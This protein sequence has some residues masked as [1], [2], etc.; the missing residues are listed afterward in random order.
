MKKRSIIMPLIGICILIGVLAIGVTAYVRMNQP[1]PHLEC[2]AMRPMLSFNGISYVN[3]SQIELA[4]APAT[5][6]LDHL[7]G[8]GGFG[9]HDVQYDCS[10]LSTGEQ[11]YSL[12]GYR[13][14]F[15]LAVRSSN[16]V[17]IFDIGYNPKA[18]TGADLFDLVN[19]VQSMAVAPIDNPD[20]PATI[21]SDPTTVQK[22][23]NEVLAAPVISNCS[24][25]GNEQALLF[26]MKDG[27][28]FE[29]EYWPTGLGLETGWPQCVQLPSNF[30]ASLLPN[31]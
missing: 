14:S 10:L 18:K 22:L 4:H 6:Q 30:P 13:P 1:Q 31:R 5:S 8:V 11:V 19:K 2:E 9:S 16:G 21:I 24:F 17:F 26:H 7:V 28:L 20:K 25:A 3:P 15:R 12:K 23:V 27:S 29:L